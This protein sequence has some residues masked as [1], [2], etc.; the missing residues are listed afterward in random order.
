MEHSGGDSMGT[1]L[2]QARARLAILLRMRRAPTFGSNSRCTDRRQKLPA[3]PFYSR[4]RS[5]PMPVRQIGY[6]PVAPWV[7]VAESKGFEPLEHLRAQRFSRR[8]HSPPPPSKTPRNSDT[9]PVPR[10]FIP[11]LRV[12]I[13]ANFMATPLSLSPASGRDSHLEIDDAWRRHRPLA[14]PSTRRRQRSST[15]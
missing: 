11:S 2:K 4:Q 8:L 15:R 1:G 3:K 14:W 6:I 12:P 13:M 10:G 5:G 7:V 9:L